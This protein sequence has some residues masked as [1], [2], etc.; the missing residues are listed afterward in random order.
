MVLDIAAWYKAIY[1][2]HF[3]QCAHYCINSC[4]GVIRS[5][6]TKTI[7]QSLEENIFLTKLWYS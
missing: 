2:H 6:S 4:K 3:H 1:T 7:L 5:R